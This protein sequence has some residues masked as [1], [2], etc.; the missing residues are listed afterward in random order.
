MANADGSAEVD[1]Y[2]AKLPAA[3]R[4]ALEHV[5]AVIA[6]TV[7]D[8]EEVISYGMPAFRQGKTLVGYAAFKNHLSFFPMSAAVFDKLDGDVAPFKTSK[9]TLQF[10]VE[11]MLPDSLIEEMVRVRLE[12]I[13]A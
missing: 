9:G 5:R 4:E 3:Q 6:R 12:E 13:G 10:T 7:P 8:A 2:L 11:T 1:S